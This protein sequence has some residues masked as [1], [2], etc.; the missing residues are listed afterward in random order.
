[1]L[2][3]LA[4]GMN[5]SL[6]G[7]MGENCPVPKLEHMKRLWRPHIPHCLFQSNEQETHSKQTQEG[8]T[9]IQLRVT[10]GISSHEML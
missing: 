10:S 7:L 5:T 6:T 1:M 2:K 4:A 8:C 9:S 3:I